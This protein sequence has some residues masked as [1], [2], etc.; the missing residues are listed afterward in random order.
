[1]KACDA[2]DV[3]T[4]ELSAYL[5]Q[6][7]EV[8]RREPRDD[9]LSALIN[10]EDDGATLDHAELIATVILLVLAGHETTANVIGNAM[11]R[12]V[13]DR[14]QIDEVAA[15]DDAAMKQGVEELLRLDGPVQMAERITLEPAD[16]GGRQLPAG[17]IVILLLVSANRDPDVFPDPHRMRLD[18]AP[19]PHLAFGSGAHFCIGAPLA[20]PRV[21][22]RHAGLGPTSAANPPPRRIASLPP[23]LHR[24]RPRGVAPHLVRG[25][26]SAQ[27]SSTRGQSLAC[28]PRLSPGL[29]GPVWFWS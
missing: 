8:R 15:C 28:R 6:L 20:R 4:A 12:M 7:I 17:R 26:D 27:S 21:A 16:V 19:N 3:A 22:Y 10:A 23:E 24:P 1:M 9:L 18:R 25:P 13:G 11:L 5:D 14:R 2:R 29:T